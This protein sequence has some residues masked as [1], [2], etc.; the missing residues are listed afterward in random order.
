MNIEVNGMDFHANLQK[1][2]KVKE[3]VLGSKRVDENIIATHYVVD[4]LDIIISKNTEEM[5]KALAKLGKS[6]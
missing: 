2:K 1:L 5:N 6:L 3:Y 4:I